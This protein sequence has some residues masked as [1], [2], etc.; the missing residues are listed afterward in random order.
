MAAQV[1]LL[2]QLMQSFENVAFP[3]SS[4]NQTC[5]Y[6][7]TGCATCPYF[8]AKNSIHWVSQDFLLYEWLHMAFFHMLM[9]QLFSKK[10]N[11]LWKQ[12]IACEARGN[13]HPWKIAQRI[14]NCCW[15]LLIIL[16]LQQSVTSTPSSQNNTHKGNLWEK[17]IAGHITWCNFFVH[18][19]LQLATIFMNF[20]SKR[21]LD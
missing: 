4:E 14:A 1:T 17:S 6:S 12:R 9:M 13:L 11:C 18:I 21:Y 15:G 3:V 19:V 8:V 5:S 20:I 2:A 16:S 10:M 7:C